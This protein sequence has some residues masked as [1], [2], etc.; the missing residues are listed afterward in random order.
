MSADRAPL[1]RDE[2]PLGV[3]LS[4]NFDGVR[5]QVIVAVS[6]PRLA[7]SRPATPSAGHS[8][9]DYALAVAHRALHHHAK[10]TLESLRQH[11]NDAVACF[12]EQ[13]E[14]TERADRASAPAVTEPKT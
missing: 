13:L 3:V 14:A 7:R 9:D 4:E 2:A 6:A 10:A 5:V 12:A 11:G 1:M 8:G